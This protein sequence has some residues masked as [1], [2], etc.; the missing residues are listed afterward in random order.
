VSSGP[1]GH[2]LDLVS[3][4]FEKMATVAAQGISWFA[5]KLVEGLK[6]ITDLLSGEG[7][8]SAILSGG[9]KAEQ[10]VVKLFTPIYEALMGAWPK[11][12]EAVTNLLSKA[13]DLIVKFDPDMK[14]DNFFANLWRPISAAIDKLWPQIQE[15]FKKLGNYIVK[16]LKEAWKN[17]L[18]KKA[19]L[20]LA[21]VVF[22]PAAMQAFIAFAVAAI[23]GILAFAA[24]YIAG[25]LGASLM[26]IISSPIVIIGVAA[27][28]VSALSLGISGGVEKFKGKMD[29][30]LSDAQKNIGSGLAGLIDAMTLGLLGDD[31]PVSI[32]NWFGELVGTFEKGVN[33][34]APGLGTLFVSFMNAGIKIYK[35]IGDIITGIIG[36]FIGEE[37][38]WS[39]IGSGLKSVFSGIFDNVFNFLSLGFGRI[40]PFVLGWL[41]TFT[42]EISAAFWKLTGQLLDAIG[43]KGLG[44]IAASIGSVISSIGKAIRV[45]WDFVGAALDFIITAIQWGATEIWE[46]IKDFGGLI[47][48]AWDYVKTEVL[49]M[50]TDTSS[51]YN[52]LFEFVGKVWDS[53]VLFFKDAAEMLEGFVGTLG[54]GVDWI[55]N[56]TGKMKE[57]M[58]KGKPVNTTAA[59][60]TGETVGAN[61]AEAMFAG[62]DKAAAAA[63]KKDKGM[64]ASMKDLLTKDSEGDVTEVTTAVVG[65]LGNIEKQLTSVT[66]ARI[67]K[68]KASFQTTIGLL[69]GLGKS[70]DQDMSKVLDTSKT[71]TTINDAFGVIQAGMTAFETITT[72]M[73]KLGSIDLKAL[74]NSVKKIPDVA[75]LVAE[76]DS[77]VNR[78]A[79]RQIKDSGLKQSLEVAAGLIK[80]ANELD[81]Q[82]SS[83]STNKI[84]LSASL[85]K[86]ATKLGVNGKSYT[87][88]NNGVQMTVFF[89]IKMSAAEVEDVILLRKESKIRDRLNSVKSG[90]D[91]AADLGTVPELP[92]NPNTKVASIKGN[93]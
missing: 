53:F 29:E 42:L 59:K 7:D 39:K 61:T 77:T 11:V 88:N 81:A 74:E 28:I 47:S 25:A 51:W 67:E 93:F 54:K 20:G 91:S 79:L 69:E 66:A 13:I 45:G 1:G 78:E 15:A 21:V 3:N 73:L 19:L 92:N 76:L 43:L 75:K 31:I 33:S 68:M 80:S 30:S 62:R 37:G 55:R 16:E 34:L 89:E 48:S 56:L 57:D 41:A 2:L 38:S 12:A 49:G 14:G 70:F 85:Q 60:R 46:E 63:A 71:F 40:L 36:L 64:G 9:S 58:N 17:P 27:A 87:I 86:F 35:G 90:F 4:L 23:G 50:G 82:L 52:D 22:G 6:Y 8:M 65:K 24:P 44:S 18:F 5:D 72:K 26:A 84:K 32:A 10:F 83:S